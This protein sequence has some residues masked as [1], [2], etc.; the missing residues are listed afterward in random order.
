LDRIK[1]ARASLGDG[2]NDDEFTRLLRVTAS[3]TEAGFTFLSFSGGFVMLTVPRQDLARWYPDEGWIVAEKE[4]IARGIAEKH[5][6]SLCEPP[7]LSS[8]ARLSSPD[9]PTVH[10]HLEL[11]NQVETVVVAHP[12]YLKVRLF[13]AAPAA[14]YRWN[15]QAPLRLGRA[16]LA[17]LSALYQP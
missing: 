4:R 14:R 15:G 11:T 17:D 5:G 13:G 3:P 2:L 6:L 9:G 16:L 7:D 12:Q 1:N 8:N 10:H